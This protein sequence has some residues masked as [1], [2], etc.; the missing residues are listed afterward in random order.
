MLWNAQ[1]TAPYNPMT[2]TAHDTELMRDKGSAR[3]VLIRMSHC[4]MWWRESVIPSLEIAPDAHL[5]TRPPLSPL[6]GPAG[7]LPDC[8]IYEPG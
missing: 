8:A 2:H 1:E 7:E 6:L 4:C 3:K 5:S